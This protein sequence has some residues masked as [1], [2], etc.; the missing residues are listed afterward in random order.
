VDVVA[1]LPPPLLSHLRIVLAREH[2][3]TAVETWRAAEAVLRQRPADALIVDPRV[4]DPMDGRALGRLRDRHPT[5]PVVVYTVLTAATLRAVVEMARQGVE[6]VVLHRF[7][8]EP[9][10][11]LTLLEQLPG[12]ALSDRLLAELAGAL[13]RLPT[14]TARAVER[15]VRLPHRFGGVE[16]LAAAS[17]V[18]VRQLYR[19]LEAAGIASPRWLV[20]GARVLR[21]FAYLQDRGCSIGAAARKLGYSQS[22][23]L[24]RQMLEVAGRPATEARRSLAPETMVELLS[25]KL[26]RA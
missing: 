13:D 5:V 26:R 6:H 24:A 1:F 17:G 7:D 8:D 20:Q 23:V 3:L 11:F 21:A 12:Y 4:D 14:P 16:D 25:E 18:T 10:R 15:L 22:R 2:T 9:R 19:Q